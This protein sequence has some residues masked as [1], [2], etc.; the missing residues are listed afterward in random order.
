MWTGWDAAS[1]VVVVAP[2]LVDTIELSPGRRGKRGDW[3]YYVV[4]EWRTEGINGNSLT[5]TT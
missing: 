4:P 1:T 5:S 3:Y 2:L